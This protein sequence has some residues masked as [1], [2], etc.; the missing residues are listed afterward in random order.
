VTGAD[1]ETTLERRF[2]DGAMRNFDGDVNRT[3]LSP[4]YTYEPRATE[5]PRLFRTP[6]EDP[7]NEHNITRHEAEPAFSG[8]VIVATSLHAVDPQQ[9]IQTMMQ[10]YASAARLRSTVPI[11]VSGIKAIGCGERPLTRV[12]FWQIVTQKP[13]CSQN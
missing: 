12:V 9:W 3:R 11:L 2:D 4:S 5:S 8:S 7:Y 6:G 1:V 13:Q 10:I